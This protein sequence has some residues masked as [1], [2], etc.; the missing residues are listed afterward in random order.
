VQRQPIE[1]LD[2]A[3][4]ELPLMPP[5]HPGSSGIHAARFDCPVDD[6]PVRGIFENGMKLRAFRDTQPNTQP[7]AF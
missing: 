3:Y 6:Y 7:D 1:Y 4:P 5:R 2:E